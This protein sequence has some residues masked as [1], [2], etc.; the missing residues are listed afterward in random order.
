MKAHALLLLVPLL[1]AACGGLR[2]P[3]RTVPEPD[4]LSDGQRDAYLSA[5][6]DAAAG[7]PA[8][9]LAH[10]EPLAALRPLHV[11]SHLLRQDLLRGE[12]REEEA[13]LE[14]GALAAE[15]GA[16]ADAEVL[17]V[18]TS[19]LPGPQRVAAY[20]AAAARD[21]ASPW[22]RIALA[23]AR[24]KQARDLEQGSRERALQGFAVESR[25]LHE[26]AVAAAGRARTE[27]ERAVALAPDLAAS[28][29]C[30]AGALAEAADLA[31][32]T[33]EAA[34]DLRGEAVDA[35]GKAL[36]IDPGDPRVLLERALLHR[37]SQ[38]LDEALR[39]FE[40]AALAAPRDREI[41][42][43]R[44]AALESRGRTGEALAAWREL[45]EMEPRWTEAWM[46]GA[47]ASLGAGRLDEALE[48]YRRA[49][50]LYAEGGGE[51]W[52]ALRG[53]AT[54]LAQMGLD[55]AEPDRLAEALGT[56]RAYAAEGGPDQA[57]VESMIY[58]LGGEEG[59]A[60]GDPDGGDGARRRSP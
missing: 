48:R 21:A 31:R 46:D 19:A 12:G 53:G 16:T 43:E 11:P 7:L 28:H 56:V 14:Y 30:L 9:A 8:K 34:R 27:A 26:E 23:V 5:L 3:A 45:L 60:A 47:G 17:R 35:C 39:D 4:R 55:R 44:A 42:A 15:P 58:T 37:D 22:P 57:W 59:G 29:A 2:P 18:R 49:D 6:E 10:L 54:T 20:Q 41:L 50:V 24:R 38:K 13:A 25:A 40:A 52:R 51:R 33:P 1:S 32:G 36:A